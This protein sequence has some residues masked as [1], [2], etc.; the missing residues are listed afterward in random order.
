MGLNYYVNPKAIGF[1]SCLQLSNPE[2]FDT[3]LKHIA[4]SH[5]PIFQ[6]PAWNIVY[7]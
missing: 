7:G 1:L 2:S 5:N 6:V 3:W 4:P